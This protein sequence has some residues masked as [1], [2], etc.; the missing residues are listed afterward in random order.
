MLHTVGVIAQHVQLQVLVPV[1]EDDEELVG[2]R[3][4]G[5][6]IAALRDALAAE[7]HAGLGGHQLPLDEV[8]GRAVLQPGQGHGRG[9]HHAVG[10]RARG[11]GGPRP[12]RL[13][14]VAA[15]H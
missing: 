13:G 12:L 15:V 2:G 1:P 5:G 4:D 14:A 8:T 7:P 11:F 9:P 10:L 3:F 6:Q